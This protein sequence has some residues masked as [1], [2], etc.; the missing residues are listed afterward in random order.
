MTSK[1][2]IKYP[3]P[4]NSGIDR[5][6][7]YS[8]VKD[9]YMLNRSAVNP[10]TDIFS[11]RLSEI[12]KGRVIESES[13]SMCLKWTIPDNWNV[14][15]G[16][17]KT[18]SGEVIADF[19]DHPLYLW[20][21]SISFNGIVS[22]DELIEN[23]I[24]TSPN[25]PNDFLYHYMHGYQEGKKEW[26]F[27]LPYN[28]VKSLDEDE[29]VVEIDADLN[30]NN[31]LK[32]VDSHIPGKIKDTIFIMAHTCHPG[33]AGDG[34]ACIAVANEVFFWLKNQ[35]NLKYSY[36]FIYGPEYWGGAT[37]LEHAPVEDVSN[38][39]FG[40]FLDMLS[41]HEPLGFQESM[42]G[43]SLFDRVTLNVFKSH[44]EVYIHRE[45]RKL[46]GNDE[47][48]YNGAGFKIPTLGIG[49]GMHREYHYNTDNLENM[50]LYNMEESAW[51]LMRIIEVMESDYI[52]VLSYIG[53]LYL[54]RYGLFINKHE[55]PEGYA[56]LEKIQALAD[57]QLSC[58]DISDKLDLDFYFVRN[59]FDKMLEKDLITRIERNP[60]EADSGFL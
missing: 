54:S 53:P 32:V 19:H 28:V 46:W 34:I 41:T 35:K 9:S 12:L 17:L 33:Q 29:Y 50:S 23:H 5:G 27:S 20:T 45:F 15:K 43:N 48:F 1:S 47:T 60:I 25:R 22:K 55:D 6:R 51:I 59:F 4:Y 2:T 57:G 10:D 42:Q 14:R 44:K 30:N 18:K 24:L 39:K 36:R 40:V 26:G 16:Q 52:P 49:R 37:W 3:F 31:T 56:N 38:L 13:G 21:H 58:F 7:M 11:A 8:L